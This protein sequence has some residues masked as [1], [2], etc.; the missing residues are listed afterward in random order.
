[1]NASERQIWDAFVT[2]LG[3]ANELLWNL[4]M[5]EMVIFEA[6][7]FYRQATGQDTPTWRNYQSVRSNLAQLAQNVSNRI[8]RMNQVY[9]LSQSGN[10]ILAPSKRVPGDLDVYPAPGLSRDTLNCVRGVPGTLDAAFLLPLLPWIVKGGIVLAGGVIAWAIADEI[11]DAQ[12][13]EQQ[14]RL[15]MAKLEQ[16]TISDL[17]SD[18]GLFKDWTSYKKK[19]VQETGGDAGWGTNIA[20]AAGGIGFAALAIGGLILGA[21]FLRGRGGARAS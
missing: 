1:M 9:A 13:Q 5:Q 20:K 14:V 19:L 17:Q 7:D 2:G 21:M 15:E 8:Q 12:K 18:P 10:I 11:T 16:G 3:K 4:R 6:N